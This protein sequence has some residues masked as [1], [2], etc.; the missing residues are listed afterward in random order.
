MI[1]STSAARPP[2]RSCRSSLSRVHRTHL[3]TIPG[4]EVAGTV[5]RIGSDVDVE[6]GKRVGAH[7]GPVPDGYAE[8]AVTET[9]RLHE[10]P[11]NSDTE[12]S[13]AAASLALPCVRAARE[14]PDISDAQSTNSPLTTA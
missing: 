1:R 5:D 13:T 14:M 3:P 9:A 12:R 10:M 11:L 2:P 6:L 8:S 4:R 7:L